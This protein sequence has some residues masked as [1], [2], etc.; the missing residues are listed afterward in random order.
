MRQHP[1][2]FLRKDLTERKIITCAEVMNARDGRWIYTAALVL[3]RQKPGSAKGVMFNT[4]EDKTGSANIVIWPTLF[5]NRR[6]VILGS[7]MMAV[8]GRIQREGEVVHLVPQQLF[9]LSSDLVGLADRDTGFKLPT[10]RG[11]EFAN[12]AAGRIREIGRRPLSHATCSCPIFISI[13][14]R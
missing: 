10:G 11:D 14:S 3:V 5:E 12:A 13:R 1:V 8:N 2:A 6:R 7:S 4:V 9:D